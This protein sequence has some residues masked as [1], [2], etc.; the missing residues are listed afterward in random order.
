[1]SESY[2]FRLFHRAGLNATR[3]R[4]PSPQPGEYANDGSVVPEIA[5]VRALSLET[6]RQFATKVAGLFLFV[7]LLLELELPRLSGMRSCPAPSRSRRCR[8][9]GVAG[10][11]APRQEANESH[12][13]PVL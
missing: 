8:R 1:M 2:L 13:R 3:N 12:Q 4:R 7:P 11:Q 5:D 10:P 9:A 6:G